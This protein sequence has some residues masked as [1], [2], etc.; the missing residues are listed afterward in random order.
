VRIIWLACAALGVLFT[1]TPHRFVCTDY[2]QGKVF[3]VDASGRVEWSYDAEHAN[4]VW[5]LPN[6]NLLFNTGHGVKEVTRDRR[7]VFSYQSSS[8]IYACQRLK[9]G[10][11]FIGECNTGRLLE[12]N[13]AGEIVKQVRLLPEGKDGGH[14]YMRNARKLPNGNYLVCHYGA[15]DVTEYDPQG[16]PVRVIPA[17]GGAHS[18]I[19]LANGNTLIASADSNHAVPRVFEVDP[20]GN[21][22]WGVKGDE[23]PG[24]SLKFMTGLQRLPNGNTV[25]TNWLGHNHFGEA[26]HIIEVT[27]DKKVVWT[28]ADHAAMRTVSS[29]QLLDPGTGEEH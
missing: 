20:D 26:P 19:R 7:V 14:A 16:K 18:A 8:E 29:V 23:L 4:D 21:T 15:G 12:V 24:I 13:P 22:V 11:T 3:V 5:A 6:G 17:P 28:F 25:M 9:N 1:G 27:R 10:N 2:T